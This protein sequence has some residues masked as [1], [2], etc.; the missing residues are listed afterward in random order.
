[1]SIIIID[2]TEE[3]KSQGKNSVDIPLSLSIPAIALLDF[4]A[5]DNIITFSFA[6]HAPNQ[7][8]Q[9]ISPLTRDKTWINYSSI[10]EEGTTNYI[11]VSISSGI[12]PSETTIT[13]KVSN[14]AGA[15]AGKLGK[16]SNQIILTYFPQCIISEIGSCYTGSGS[17]KG[18]QLV[19]NWHDAD[20]YGRSIFAK[21]NYSITVTYT[22]ASS[23]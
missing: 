9:V 23:K 16:P 20:N 21:S 19:Y 11:T 15:G 1:M 10:V 8:E 12:L 6:A 17:Y 3:L 5:N 2:L 18:H 14:D 13:V 4:K 22:I 7:V